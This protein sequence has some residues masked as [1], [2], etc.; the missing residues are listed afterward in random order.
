MVHRT[1]RGGSLLTAG[2]ATFAMYHLALAF[3][4]ATAPHAFYEAVGPFGP[5]NDH[6]VRDIATYNA[7]LAA[8][9]GVATGRE[10]WRV[11]V[12]TVTTL[13]FALHTVNHL[14]D[15]GNADPHWTGYFDFI[16]LA[17]A[18]LLLAL[19]LSAAR[20]RARSLPSD[21]QGGMR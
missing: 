10:S 15:I 9:L 20:A 6:Y 13:Q 18:T 16:S 17:L 3:F 21:P 4:M 19:L 12:L 11:P 8:G 7:A 14:V 2:I 5:A 1:E